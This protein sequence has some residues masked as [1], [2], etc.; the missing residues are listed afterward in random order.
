MSKETLKHV[1]AVSD[2]GTKQMTDGAMLFASGAKHYFDKHV[3]P[4][5]RAAATKATK[6][7]QE[8]LAEAKS[9]RESAAPVASTVARLAPKAALA[10]SVLMFISLWLP[11]DKNRTYIADGSGDQY[12]ILVL[13]LVAAAIASVNLIKASASKALRLST[14]I[15]ALLTGIVAALSGFGTMAAA[16]A[17]FGG[18]VMAFGALA[19]IAAGAVLLSASHLK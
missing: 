17:S 19:L 3:A 10:L 13:A 2:H 14:A 18:F 9:E 8:Q 12:F 6:A 5:A 4:A 15:A 11:V 1:P 7:L 16:G